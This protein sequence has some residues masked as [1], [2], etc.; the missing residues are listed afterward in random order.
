[1][2]RKVA[3]AMAEAEHQKKWQ[4]VESQQ[5]HL[6]RLTKNVFGLILIL[7]WRLATVTRL[8]TPSP[9]LGPRAP[10]ASPLTDP[11]GFAS[12]EP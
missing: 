11:P 5:G 6:N 8:T 1:M 4:T 2:E 3:E 10:T 9:Q 12:L 7:A